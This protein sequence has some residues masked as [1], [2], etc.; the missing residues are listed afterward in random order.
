MADSLTDLMPLV[1]HLSVLFEDLRASDSAESWKE[2]ETT[3]RSL[4]NGL[5]TRDDAVDN[6]SNLGETALP[7]TLKSI[8]LLALHGLS[9]PP[10]QYTAVV[11]ELLRVAANLSMD[12]DENRGR[13]LEAGLPQAIVALL[14]GYVE[15]ISPFSYTNP[16]DFT[17]P[18]LKV[19]KTSVGALLN[20]SVGYEAIQFRLISLEAPLTILKLSSAIYPTGYWANPSAAIG[21]QDEWA[22]RSGLSDWGWLAISELKDIKDDAPPII[23]P[24]FLP[25]LVQPLVAYLAMDPTSAH[26]LS[27]MAPEVAS[28]LVDVDFRNLQE[29][30]MLIESSALDLENV[31]LS[32]ARGIHSPVTPTEQGDLHCLSIILD[33]IER[34]TYPTLWRHTIPDE[35]R[36]KKMEKAFNICK[37][38]LIKAVVEV[39][40]EDHIGNVLWNDS[41]SEV[42]GGKFVRRM[43]DWLKR[44]VENL[45]A[46]ASDHTP[47]IQSIS[48]RE[49]MVICASLS[50]GNLIRHEKSSAAIVSPPYS[51]VPVLASPHLLSSSTDIKVKHG[52]IALLKHLAQAPPSS[53]IIQS[54]LGKAEILRRIAASG[55]WDEK[56]DAM[57]D[58]VQLSAIGVAKHMA[59]ANVEHAYVLVLPSS[60]SLSS[61]TGLSQ[62]IALVKRT[63][64]VPIKSEGSRVLVNI[65]R[66][67]W[68]NKPTLNT[69]GSDI[70]PSIELVD[71]DVQ[72][73]QKRH[74]AA[75]HVIL[76]SENASVLAKL[77]G[78]SGKYPLLVNEGLVALTMFSIPKEG[79]L[80]VL[81][82]LTASLGVEIPPESPFDSTSP[83]TTASDVG[84]PLSSAPSRNRVK[85]NVPRHPLDMLV[86]TLRNVDNPANFPSEVRANVCS[87]LIQLSKH[88]HGDKL[89]EVKEAIQPVLEALLASQGLEERLVN[90]MRRLQDA[91]S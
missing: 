14:E 40:G 38:A 67:L 9:I 59:S 44:Y 60:R 72:E 25:L 80:L 52:V 7:Q 56:S 10:D 68:G 76:T 6:H 79:A 30:C 39:A 84:S 12:H 61:P 36:R 66:T 16:A 58:I 23:N 87:F 17:I 69:A 28:E 89:E 75:L 43:V 64:S 18:H 90:A 82:A 88:I 50:L 65:V 5:R 86:F 33:F 85:L 8:L 13:L 41:E 70:P 35:T 42:P 71:Q 3:F 19:I 45:D 51:L 49:D 46:V 48:D 81:D 24:D 27:E 15:D 47:R 4:A 78:S 31:R 20:A 53:T 91:W 2:V 62:I 55:V 32:L 34:G 57:A 22:L 74:N 83:P 11:F 21:D 77:V 37:A 63:D 29:S 26:P 73:K 54:A 1:G